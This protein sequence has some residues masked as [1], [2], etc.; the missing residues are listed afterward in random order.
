LHGRVNVA[1]FLPKLTPATQGAIYAPVPPTVHQPRAF[2]LTLSR[3]KSSVFNAELLWWEVYF[4]LVLAFEMLE[5]SSRSGWDRVLVGQ[6]S[7]QGIP[8]NIS[9]HHKADRMSE[10]KLPGV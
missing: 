3:R 5:P 1:Y 10:V 8:W 2:L 4:K 6:L 7:L 9:E